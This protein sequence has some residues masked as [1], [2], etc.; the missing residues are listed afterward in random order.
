MAVAPDK[1][2]GKPA[3]SKPKVDTT[4]GSKAEALIETTLFASRW[5]LAPLYLGLLVALVALVAMFLRELVHVAEV[6]IAPKAKAEDV[7]LLVLS[8]IDLSLAANL[9][10]IIVFSGYENFVS[11]MDNIDHPDRPNWM[12]KI[13]FGGLK[14]KLMASVAAISAIQLLKVFV[15]V[16]DTPPDKIY[17]QVVIHLTFVGSGVLLAIMDYITAKSKNL[18]YSGD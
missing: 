1:A 14:L 2:S 18:G 6:L 7:I 5:L 8:L 13:D 11:K 9:V 3:V 12:G 4:P 15:N 10:L 17:W 16:A